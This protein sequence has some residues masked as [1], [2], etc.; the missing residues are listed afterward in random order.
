MFHSQQQRQTLSLLEQAK[1]IEPN[2]ALVGW[3]FAR[4]QLKENNPER[5][6]QIS[7]QTICRYPDDVK[8]E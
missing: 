6:L 4:L 1:I 8:K 2:N 3:N 7:Q 5:A